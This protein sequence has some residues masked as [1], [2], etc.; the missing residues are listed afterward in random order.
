MHLQFENARSVLPAMLQLLFAP[1]VAT[2]MFGRQCRK[3]LNNWL[4]SSLRWMKQLYAVSA[5]ASR[6]QR[7]HSSN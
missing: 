2:F 7:K 3:A 1:A 6:L 5:I 4:A